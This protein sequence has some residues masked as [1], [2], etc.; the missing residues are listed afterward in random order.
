MIIAATEILPVAR[1]LLV[2]SSALAARILWERLVNSVHLAS[3]VRIATSSVTPSSRVE[4]AAIVQK[5]AIVGCIEIR[6]PLSAHNV[7]MNSMENIR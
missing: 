5:M 4:V 1:V 3:M 2:S 6:H 7:S